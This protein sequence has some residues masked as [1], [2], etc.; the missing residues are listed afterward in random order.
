MDESIM[1]DSQMMAKL[2]EMEQMER[3][4]GL[5][6]MVQIVLWSKERMLPSLE[7][8]RAVNRGWAVI[9]S[10]C[11]D[12]LLD[13]AGHVEQQLYEVR[14]QILTQYHRALRGRNA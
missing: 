3:L 14:E 5:I 9:V 11:R 2:F 1:A 10:G 7:E 6:R 12:H 8:S 13:L 4:I